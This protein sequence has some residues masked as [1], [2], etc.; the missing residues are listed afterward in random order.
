MS[1]G[2]FHFKKQQQLKDNQILISFSDCKII[3]STK[4]GLLIA[5][6]QSRQDNKP[7]AQYLF[8]VSTHPFFTKY[9]LY[10]NSNRKAA[11]TITNSTFTSFTCIY[12]KK[13]FLGSLNEHHH[14][15]FVYSVKKKSYFIS[16]T[17]QPKLCL[18]PLSSVVKIVKRERS[19]RLLIHSTIIY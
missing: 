19:Q 17:K 3:P 18:F 6:V 14:Y 1:E 12:Q 9:F 4:Y 8:L 16:F 13:S 15:F 5:S 2:C 11:A 10:I 7:K